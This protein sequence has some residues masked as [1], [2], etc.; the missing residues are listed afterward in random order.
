LACSKDAE[1]IS[2]N[3]MPWEPENETAT[4]VGVSVFKMPIVILFFL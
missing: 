4:E 3:E 1:G 2:E